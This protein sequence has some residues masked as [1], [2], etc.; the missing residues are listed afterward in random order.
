MLQIWK[1]KNWFSPAT[2]CQSPPPPSPSWLHPSGLW[3]GGGGRGRRKCPGM[4]CVNQ[5]R[6]QSSPPLRLWFLG[7]QTFKQEQRNMGG[8]GGEG[9][10]VQ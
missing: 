8:G 10:G 5:G 3:A 4:V 7:S 2:I 9:G 1:P 6:G